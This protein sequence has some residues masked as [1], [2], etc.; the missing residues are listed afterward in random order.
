MEEDSNF[1]KLFFYLDK[2]KISLILGLLGI[3]LIGIGLLLPKL[4]SQ[5]DELKVNNAV[6]AK[7]GKLKVDVAGAVK[8]PGVYELEENSRCYL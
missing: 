6:E 4:N 2:Y 7:T 5:R 8:E 3:L 1:G